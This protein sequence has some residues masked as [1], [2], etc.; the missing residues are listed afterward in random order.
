MADLLDRKRQLA[1][2]ADYR[3]MAVRNQ[4]ENAI[5]Q[6]PIAR[7]QI[8][9][10]L[11][12]LQSDFQ[13]K[14][15]PLR[16]QIVDLQQF[17]DSYLHSNGQPSAELQAICRRNDGLITEFD[18]KFYRLRTSLADVE[19]VYQAEMKAEERIVEASNQVP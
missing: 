9:L 10:Q 2:L 1:G 16:Q 18:E 13:G 17:C 7:D 6:G 11:Q 8:H 12:S 15:V 14:I 3:A 5:W 4:I 19:R